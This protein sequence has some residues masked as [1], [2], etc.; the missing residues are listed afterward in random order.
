LAA[1]VLFEEPMD[2]DFVPGRP[3]NFFVLHGVRTESGA[4][5]SF[6][7]LFLSLGKGSRD[8]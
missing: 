8:V 5:T 2:P 4:Y 3:N 7:E 6:D 1:G